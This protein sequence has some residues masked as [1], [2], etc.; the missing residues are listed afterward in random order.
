MFYGGRLLSHLSAL[1]PEVAEFISLRRLNRYISI[2]IDSDRASSRAKLNETKIRVRREFDEG[3]GF[4]WIT[5]GRE[6]EN[7]IRPTVLEAAVKEVHKN[8]VRLAKT[9]QF[10]H[11]LFY[12]KNTGRVVEKVDKVKI[13]H[14]VVKSAA[15]LDV[16]DLRKMVSQ[17]IRFIRSA[18]DF[19]DS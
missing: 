10:D 2:M 3:P 1:D 14:E 16:L 9:G 5:K 12:K 15:D 17:L 4:A 6:I 11:C 7:Y 13:A 8:A 18:N 19:A